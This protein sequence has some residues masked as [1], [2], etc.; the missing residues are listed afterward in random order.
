MDEVNKSVPKV[1]NKDAG[2]TIEF[3]NDGVYLTVFDSD[4]P[5]IKF[6]LSD[7]AR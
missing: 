7:I 5:G 3:R 6:E 4:E 2:Y 1:G